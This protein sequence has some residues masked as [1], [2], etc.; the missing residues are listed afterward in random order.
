MS[1]PDLGRGGGRGKECGLGA[2][3][4]LALGC[5]APDA[6]NVGGFVYDA[7]FAKRF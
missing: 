2:C 6:F 7:Q 4:S 5:F 1:S 3:A